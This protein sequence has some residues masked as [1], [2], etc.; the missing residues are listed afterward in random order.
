MKYL[1][2]IIWAV[3]LA[4]LLGG[5]FALIA[6]EGKAG[7][8]FAFFSLISLAVYSFLLLRSAASKVL[9][10]F[11]LIFGIEWLLLPVAAG[12]NANQAA[13]LGGAIGAGMMLALSVPIGLLMRLLFLALAF[14]KFR[15]NRGP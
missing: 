14:Y 3:L 6:E 11:S 5:L 13:T 9:F 2:R 1:V 10:R 4:F 7:D 8:L 12:I 15:P